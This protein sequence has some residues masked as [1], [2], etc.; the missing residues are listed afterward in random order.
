MTAPLR[1]IADTNVLVSAICFPLGVCAKLLSLTIDGSWQMVVSPII[2]NELGEVLLRNKF[3]RYLG[4]D[5]CQRYISDIETLA[6]VIDDPITAP[7]RVTRDPK[8]DFLIA[9]AYKA[10]V[11]ILISG[12]KDLQD[13]KLNNLLVRSPKEFLSLLIER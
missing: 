10:S 11:E 1:A 8:D 4:V 7:L 12:D 6:E 3:R 2:F 9:L 5:Q 13:L